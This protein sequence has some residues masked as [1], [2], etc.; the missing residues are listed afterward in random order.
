MSGVLESQ[1]INQV[2]STLATYFDAV[3]LFQLEHA[4]LM[5]TFLRMLAQ[6]SEGRLVS[7]IGEDGAARYEQLTESKFVDEY[8]IDIGEA[9]TTATQKQETSLIITQL[10]EKAQQFGKN[11]WPLAIDYI[12]GIKEA[13]KQKFKE[14]LS[15]SPEEI[16]QQQAAAQDQAAQQR[17]INQSI[18]AGQ[19]ARAA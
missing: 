9:P 10:A 3:H 17:A 6:N 5:T 11:L 14:A 4:R 15:T 13:D 1:R 19:M 16:Q 2:V 8:D 12:V 18:V 7:I